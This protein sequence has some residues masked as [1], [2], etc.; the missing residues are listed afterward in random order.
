MDSIVLFDCQVMLGRVGLQQSVSRKIHGESK[1]GWR[2][3][4]ARD[5][6]YWSGYIVIKIRNTG[7]KEDYQ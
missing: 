1:P 7:R 3:Y 4:H 6:T 2:R 5:S